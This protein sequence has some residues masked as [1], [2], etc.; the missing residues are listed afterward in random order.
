MFRHQLLKGR[1]KLYSFKLYFNLHTYNLPLFNILNKTVWQIWAKPV[2][3]SGLN[4]FCL[5]LLSKRSNKRWAESKNNKSYEILFLKMMIVNCM[6]IFI[7]GRS[8]LYWCKI[9]QNIEDSTKWRLLLNFQLFSFPFWWHH[10]WS[11]TSKWE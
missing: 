7:P 1:S 6:E 10:S 11:K 9:K 8:S 4:K 5:C 2:I 3:K